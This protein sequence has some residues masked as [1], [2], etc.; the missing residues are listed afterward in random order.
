MAHWGLLRHG[1][2]KD[3]RGI[4]KKY[5]TEISLIK[6]LIVVTHIIRETEIPTLVDI[7]LTNTPSVKILC[8]TNN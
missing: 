8:D 5:I 6:Q 7:S 4:V 2:K 1:K 3:K